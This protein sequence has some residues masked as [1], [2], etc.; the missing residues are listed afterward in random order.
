MKKS[1]SSTAP[2]KSVRNVGAVDIPELPLN[3]KTAIKSTRRQ[4]G[5]V[6]SQRSEKTPKKT[7]FDYHT[8]NSRIGTI[9][10]P[11]VAQEK[12]VIEKREPQSVEYMSEIEEEEDFPDEVSIFATLSLLKTMEPEVIMQCL[13]S[14]PIFL[15]TLEM[16]GKLDESIISSVSLILESSELTTF[17]NNLVIETNVFQAISQCETIQDI[18]ATIPK[19]IPILKCIVWEKT[20]NSNYFF[21]QTLSELLPIEQSIIGHCFKINDDIVTSDPGDHPN[22]SVDRD[23]PIMRGIESMILLPV[24]DVND[25]IVCVIQCGGLYDQKNNQVPF[26]NYYTETLKI[27][28]T[29]VQK[30]IF[31]KFKSRIIPSNISGAFTELDFSTIQYTLNKITSYIQKIVPCESCE[32]YLF[33]D[34]YKK[35]TRLNDGKEFDSQTGGIAFQA[36]LTQD[37]LNIPHGQHNP[38]Y[39]QDI[40]G[41]FV[42]KSI[43]AKSFFITR[44]HYIVAFRAKLKMPI[45]SNEDADFMQ[46]AAPIIFDAIKVSTYVQK[47]SDDA[48][49]KMKS[50]NIIH[51]TYSALSVVA[52]DGV[53]PWIAARQAANA[54]F[55]TSKF[56]IAIF[57]GRS[58]NFLP[59]AVKW[60]FDECVSG[61]AYNYREITRGKQG[62][63][64]FPE[65]LYSDLGVNAHNS[66]AFPF[67]RNAK[68]AGSI[69]VIDPIVPDI[70]EESTHLFGCLIANIFDKVLSKRNSIV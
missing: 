33:D 20:Y 44:G 32:I 46:S 67:R 19:V 53:D 39:N 9:K 54:F 29:I 2:I 48:K 37:L 63:E 6:N 45:F 17:V 51:A 22:F 52:R 16:D 66:I 12:K 70:D 31:A 69:E 42:N 65:K 64:N 30:R 55:G 21:S 56:F 41:R 13:S 10:I 36:G 5:I 15:R 61:I 47:E 7:K 43:I 34:R 60:P 3:G 23:L 59:T 62:G 18:E 28:K 38:S 40:D 8:I 26:N 25:D 58:M 24:K 4:K 35:M 27:A 14:I 49:S 68:I 50:T 57:D 11:N 1:R